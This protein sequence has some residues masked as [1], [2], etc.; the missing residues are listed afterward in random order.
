[1]KQ[2]INIT[3]KALRQLI[4]IQNHH[5]S[6]FILFSAKSGGCNGFGYKLEPT[7]DEPLK[8]DEVLDFHNKDL[9]K[10]LNINICGKSLLYL[11]GTEIDWTEDVMGNRFVFD[12]PK[13]TGSCGCG[14]SF[15]I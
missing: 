4:A 12:N 1:M 13:A 7:N 11:L 5:K 9:N 14:T 3:N 8:S 10:T 2:I 15:S 6:K